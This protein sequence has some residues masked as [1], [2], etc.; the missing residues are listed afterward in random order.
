MAKDRVARNCLP[1]HRVSHAEVASSCRPITLH[2]LAPLR[3][4]NDAMQE[5]YRLRDRVA[6]ERSPINIWVKHQLLCRG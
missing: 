6:V 4:G 2:N 3:R 5:N 1:E